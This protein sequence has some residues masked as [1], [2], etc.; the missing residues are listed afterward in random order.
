MAGFLEV[1]ICDA[2]IYEP[3]IFGDARGY[4]CE[5]YR[6]NLFETRLHGRFVQLNQS[7]SSAG[8]LRGIHLQVNEGAAAK[9]VECLVGAIWDVCVDLRPDSPSFKKWVGVELNEENHRGFYVPPGCGHGFCVLGESDV[10]IRYSQTNYYEPST[11]R[12]LQWN[13]PMI[14]I[15]W[16]IEAPILSEKDA[17]APSFKESSWEACRGLLLDR[18]TT[19]QK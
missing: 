7:R 11:E 4:F 17:Q 18:S 12:T 10:V 19:A 8:V 14:G 2:F 16:P 9:L 1:G 15:E 6:E 13:D 3:E 5:L